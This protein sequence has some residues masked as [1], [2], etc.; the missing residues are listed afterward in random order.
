MLQLLIE[1]IVLLSVIG[2]RMFRNFFIK[3]SYVNHCLLYT[4]PFSSLYAF[5]IRKLYSAKTLRPS[6]A[7]GMVSTY[8]TSVL[9]QKR[10]P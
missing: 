6:L 4:G 9:Q 8:P 2:F 7:L 1:E 5:E 10:F 3:T